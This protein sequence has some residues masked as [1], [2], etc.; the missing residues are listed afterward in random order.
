MQEKGNSKLTNSEDHLLGL[1]NSTFP[2]ALNLKGERK[3]FPKTLI[4]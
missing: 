1:M 2:S 4:T 3:K